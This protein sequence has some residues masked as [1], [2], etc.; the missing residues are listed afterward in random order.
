MGGDKGSGFGVSGGTT[1]ALAPWVLFIGEMGGDNLPLY[2]FRLQN[3][4]YNPLGP[5]YKEVGVAAHTP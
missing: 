1:L 3:E 4:V 2:P 5:F